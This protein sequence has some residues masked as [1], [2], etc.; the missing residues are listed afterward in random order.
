MLKES[1]ATVSGLVLDEKGRPLKGIRVEASSCA[2]KAES[3]TDGDGRYLLEG[4][5]A[6]EP[7]NLWAVSVDYGPLFLQDLPFPQQPME[8]RFQGVANH[9]RQGRL[10]DGEGRPLA[11]ALL[12]VC[13]DHVATSATTN[14]DGSF[15][16]ARC[17]ATALFIEALADLSGM[18]LVSFWH[19][20]AGTDHLDLRLPSKEQREAL[21]KE[22]EARSN[23]FI[24]IAR[25]I[26]IPEFAY[27]SN[28]AN[29]GPL[30]V[31]NGYWMFRR[32]KRS[33]LKIKVSEEG[34]FQV[35]FRLRRVCQSAEPRLC[36][37][38]GPSEGQ[39]AIPSFD[40]Q[41]LSVNLRLPSGE[42][43]LEMELASGW[44]ADAEWVVVQPQ[45]E[46]GR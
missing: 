43:T 24:P 14:F 29:V 31:E 33:A 37:K 12:M 1:R 3:L 28:P 42:Q 15:S 32:N 26:S 39:I 45:G 25:R 4:L 7:I 5:V 40:W 20:P 17:P 21:R 19:I 46:M 23:A 35:T 8:L 38:C 16:L 27:L 36:V 10:L 44:A 18:E 11:S 30:P 34:D 2:A 13:G 22:R 6:G 41:E 9:E